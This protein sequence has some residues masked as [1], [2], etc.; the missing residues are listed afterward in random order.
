MVITT[1][2]RVINT[3]EV[4]EL[5]EIREFLGGSELAKVPISKLVVN[6]GYDAVCVLD[7][8]DQV[9]DLKNLEIS[10]HSLQLSTSPNAL[11]K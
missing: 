10:T 8:N 2:S 11:S 5:G 6:K 7:V 9:S 1:I 3:A 4:Q